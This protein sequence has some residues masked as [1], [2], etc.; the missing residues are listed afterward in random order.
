MSFV[1]QTISK[2]LTAV[3]LGALTL[4]AAAPVAAAAEREAV[5]RVDRL[6]LRPQPTVDGEPLH[7]LRKGDRLIVLTSSDKWLKVDF[8]DMVGYVR[9]HPRY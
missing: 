5:V 2:G 6:N 1:A 8:D 4:L 7:L 9:N 3:V